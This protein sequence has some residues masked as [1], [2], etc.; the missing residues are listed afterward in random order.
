MTSPMSAS[1]QALDPPGPAFVGRKHEMAQLRAGLGGAID[2]RGGMFLLSGEPGIGKTRLAE[3]IAHEAAE[4]GMAVY[5]GL[6]T[7]AEGAPPYWPWVQ[8]LRGL[9]GDLGPDEFGRLAGHRMSQI[10]RMV[11]DLRDRF[12]DVAP[13]SMDDEA[14]RFGMYDAVAQLLV[15]AAASRPLLLLLEDLHWADEPSLILL[16]Q[17]APTLPHSALLIVGTYRHRELAAEHRL[18]AQFAEYIRRGDTTEIA[19]SG[20]AD[21][22]VASLLR[23]LTDFE[24]AEEVVRRLQARTEGNPFFLKELAQYLS[25]G[26]DRPAEASVLPEGVAAVLRQRI[27]GLSPDCRRVLEIGAVIGQILDLD[28]IEAITAI[29]RLR[30]L[31]LLDEAMEKGVVAAR[32][33]HYAFAHGL[34]RDTVYAGLATARR[35]DL[36]GAVANALEQFDTNGGRVPA[37][38]LAYHYLQAASTDQTLKATARKYAIAAAN[39]ALAELAYEEAVRLLES[40][41]EVDKAADPKARANLL[42]DLGR[43]RFMAGEVVAA[44]ATAQ[45]AARIAEELRDNDLLARAALIVRG[46]G[47]IGASPQIKDLG[48]L[49]LAHPPEDVALRI[50]LLSQTAVALTWLPS[51]EAEA[52]ALEMSIEA[53]RL[54]E[55]AVDPDVAFAAI[56]AR[57]MAVSGPDGVE[58]RLQLAQRAQELSRRSGR[59]WIEQWSHSWAADALSQLGRMEEAEAELSHLRRLADELREPRLLWRTLL[60]EAWLA[61]LRGRFA[62]ARRLS[63]AALDLGRKGQRPMAE[64]NHA[65]HSAVLSL[66]V[67][68]ELPDWPAYAEDRSGWDPASKL[69][70]AIALTRMGRIEEARLAL[71]SFVDLVPA[72]VRPRFAWLFIMSGVAQAVATISDSALAAVVYDALMPY[73]AYNVAGG[74]GFGDFS[75]SVAYK[76]GMLATTLERWDDAARHF[77]HAISFESQMGAPPFAAC[78]QIAYAEML[79]RR[80]G[81]EDLRHAR[82]LA[83]EALVTTTRLGMQPWI[84]RARAVLNGL[85]AHHVAE[86]PLSRREM[87]IA[88]LVADGLTNRAIAE[89]LHLSERTAESHVKNICDKLGFSSRTQVAAWVSATRPTL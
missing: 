39:Q 31:D 75:G 74:A 81:A 76:L 43:A 41:I 30:L 25:A 45:D 10:V 27:E 38:R 47:G 69:Y 5:W 22:D 52:R 33:G 36:H 19:V 3:Q 32:D 68:G 59:K 7:Q 87:E 28:A 23:T 55:D 51:A 70:R 8:I 88:F 61:L 82:R 24:P 66:L 64:F 72:G 57:Q 71:R 12:P 14:A 46:V 11:P 84:A 21:P 13:A 40:A 60:A 4:R 80:G 63:E 16:Q 2:H 78:S 44:I 17:I 26:D 37:G 9:L 15:R 86:H 62:D 35:S 58:E 18:R 6:S 1:R 89:K 65:I 56:H 85:D 48:E 73:A 67:G 53:I 49:A 20:L 83:S 50:Q 54:A 29:T 77:E 34:F 42:I 79:V